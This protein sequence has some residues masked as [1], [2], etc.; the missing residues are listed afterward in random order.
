MGVRNGIFFKPVSHDGMICEVRSPMGR[1]LAL[2]G[3]LTD[4]EPKVEGDEAM[5]RN[6]ALRHNAWAYAKNEKQFRKF[7]LEEKKKSYRKLADSHAKTAAKIAALVD[8]VG[9]TGVDGWCSG[10]FTLSTHR[11]VVGSGGIV[12]TYRCATCGTPTL[13]CAAAWCDHMA[14]RSFGSVRLPR[15]CAEHGHEIPSF[16]RANHKVDALEQY[17]DLQIFERS[18]LAMASRLTSLGVLAAAVVGTG[19]VMAAPAIGG[20]IGSL[21]GFS[22][23]AAASYGLA[24]LGGGSLAAGGLGMVGGTYV[25]AAAGAALG[26][27]LGASVTSAYIGED[28]SFRIEKFRDGLGTP[29]VVA[30][31]FMTETDPQWRAAMQMVEKRY[32]NSPIYRLRWGSKELKALAGLLLKNVGA[33]QAAGGIAAMAARATKVGAKRLG[34]V[35]PV[36]LAADILKNPWHVAMTRADKTRA[37]LAGVLARTNC[38]SYILVG[39]S[40]GGRAVVTAAETL[41]TSSDAPRIEAVHLLGAAEGKKGDWRP[42]SESVTGAVHNYFSTN[43]AVLKDAYTAAQAGGVAVGLRGFGS[44]FSNIRDHDVSKL[45]KRHSEYFEKVRLV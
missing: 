12:P 4:V 43:D 10:C 34:A 25:V 23:A 42:L 16:E 9:P 8:F 31:G 6:P 21:A 13:G 37:A 28:K 45:V 44:R 40:L 3:T 5:L 17:G 11:K 29:V 32:P 14:V 38:A 30:R 33:G 2:T 41:G 35:A 22:G 26:G 15:F 7:K 19:G 24:M 20:A 18:N 1:L 27:A 36:L 39:H